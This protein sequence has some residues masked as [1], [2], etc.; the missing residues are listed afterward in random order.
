MF[1]HAVNSPDLGSVEPRFRF[2]RQRSFGRQYRWGERE[3]PCLINNG[4][5]EPC[6]FSRVRHGTSCSL[7]VHGKSPRLCLRGPGVFQMGAC[8]KHPKGG[9]SQ[10]SEFGC[11]ID[12][13]RLCPQSR[14]IVLST[15]HNAPSWALALICLHQTYRNH[16]LLCRGAGIAAARLHRSRWSVPP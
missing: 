2:H 5:L 9:N 3:T 4:H 8:A 15:N 7:V 13:F 1:H 12:P 16:E 10:G 6:D 11:R 14:L